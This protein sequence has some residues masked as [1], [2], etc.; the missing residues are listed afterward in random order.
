[1]RETNLFSS[2]S[3]YIVKQ[4][5]VGQRPTVTVSYKAP[6]LIDESQLKTINID[7]LLLFAAGSF[8]FILNDLPRL[9]NWHAYLFHFVNNRNCFCARVE[10]CGGNKW[11]SCT[12]PSIQRTF[13][14]V[15]RHF[16]LQ[17]LKPI[18]TLQVAPSHN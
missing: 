12:K 1:M 9:S 2:E 17:V 15:F 5:A 11:C 13:V 7:T 8:E 14:S 4:K 10:R 16:V 6:T 18:M 3:V